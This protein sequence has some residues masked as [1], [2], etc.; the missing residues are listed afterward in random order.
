MDTGHCLVT[1]PPRIEGNIRKGFLH[2]PSGGDSVV[3][4]ITVSDV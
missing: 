1:L 3:L 4:G 2:S